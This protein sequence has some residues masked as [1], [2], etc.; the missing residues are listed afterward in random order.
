MHKVKFWTLLKDILNK[1]ENVIYFD[2]KDKSIIIRNK[3]YF[4]NTIIPS[5]NLKKESFT[6]QLNNYGFQKIKSEDKSNKKSVYKNKKYEIKDFSKE[7]IELI[8]R[9]IEQEK[10]ENIK[11]A[12]YYENFKIGTDKDKVNDLLNNEKLNDENLREIFS[13]LD[14][15]NEL[16]NFEKTQNE[17]DSLKKIKINLE[18]NY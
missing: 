11:K 6:K 8:E 14:N 5:Q 10:D 9:K 17:I 1:Y 15:D 18:N 2:K 7:E 3:D 16:Y 4:F 12:N 13:Y